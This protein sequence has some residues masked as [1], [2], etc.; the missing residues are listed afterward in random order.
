ML[1][2]QRLNI[3]SIDNK[4]K[5][6]IDYVIEKKIIDIFIFNDFYFNFFFFYYF[7]LFYFFF[8]SNIPFSGTDNN[9]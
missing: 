7:I 4:R 5:S 6:L 3:N 8:Y 9:K 1:V 2:N